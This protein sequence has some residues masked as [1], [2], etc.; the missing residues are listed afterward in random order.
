MPFT[1]FD[2]LYHIVSSSFMFACVKLITDD[3][4]FHRKEPIYLLFAI[5]FFAF[6]YML[7]L[8]FIPDWFMIF[9]P[10]IFISLALIY[11]CKIKLYPF[12]KGITLTIL[13]LWLINLSEMLQFQ[14]FF[15]FPPDNIGI[16]ALGPIFHVLLHELYF[17]VLEGIFLF[18]IVFLFVKASRKLRRKINASKQAQTVLAGVSITMFL[19]MQISFLVL[20]YQLE[21]REIVTSWEAFFL[22]GFSAVMFVSVLFYVKFLKERI[23]LQQKEAEQ[24]HLKEYLE[25]VEAHQRIV[26]RISHDI[27][28]VLSSMEGY[29]A[30]NNLT[31][32][33]EYF[34]YRIKPTTKGITEDTFALARLNN[35]KVLEI[36]AILARKI[37]EAQSAGISTTLEAVDEIDHIPI[38]SVA[39]VRMLGIILDNAIEELTILG[40]GQL[41]IACYKFGGGL[42]FIVQNTCRPDIQKFHTLKQAGFSTK[43]EGRGLG[44]SNLTEIVD[45]HS[46]NITLQTSI[47]DGNFTQKLRIG[48]GITS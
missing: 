30:A 42:T 40:K 21:L 9:S 5:L 45:A 13:A 11:F 18:P 15:L 8:H 25:Q 43:G 34:Y 19:I 29:L 6:S 22:L 23:A 16:D 2:I 35:I 7:L 38:N 48:G 33:R 41:M 31:G 44:L 28:N 39:L 4:K 12:R 1:F 24:E 26:Q 10:T 36:K 27:G 20:H 32:L 47:A 37:T 17:I 14:V 3:K 46:G